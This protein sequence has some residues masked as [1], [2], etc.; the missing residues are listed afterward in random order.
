METVFT[1]LCNEFAHT[2]PGVD[3]DTTKQEMQARLPT[4]ADLVK[5]AI[6]LQP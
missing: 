4:L 3:L 1:R 5:R 6:E 2:R